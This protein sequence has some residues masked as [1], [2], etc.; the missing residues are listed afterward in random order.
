MHRE[1]G[2]H[3]G[4]RNIVESNLTL[5]FNC[6]VVKR[7]FIKYIP[8]NDCRLEFSITK[9]FCN[10]IPNQMMIYAHSEHNLF[11]YFQEDFFIK[12]IMS[13]RYVCFAFYHRR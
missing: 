12:L 8:C 1:D 9:T 10:H 3:L 7:D 4:S 13:S 2:G 6:S 11:R 5:L